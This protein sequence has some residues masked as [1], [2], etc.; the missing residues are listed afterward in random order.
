MRWGRSTASTWGGGLEWA[1]FGGFGS[2]PARF[3]ERGCVGVHSVSERE[4]E[5]W[6]SRVGWRRRGDVRAGRRGAG[7]SGRRGQYYL[8]EKDIKH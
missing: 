1:G 8:C 5:R 6:C 2:L 7:A 3:R 4:R